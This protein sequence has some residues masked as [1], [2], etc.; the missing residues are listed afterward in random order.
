MVKFF[1]NLSKRDRN[2]LAVCSFF[3]VI[4]VI[5]QFLFLPALAK[6][7][8]LNRVLKINK[9]NLDKMVLL[10]R[11]HRAFNKGSK[12][13]K[14]LLLKRGKRFSLFSFIDRVAESCKLKKN[15]A[16]MKPSFKS[17]DNTDIR[18]AFVKLRLESISLNECVDFLNKIEDRKNMVRINS[19]SISTAGKDKKMIDIVIETETSVLKN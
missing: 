9:S 11:Q 17:L 13:K 19:F 7:K 15:V 5:I 6:R 2:A 8:N 4:F 16:Y 3:L 14:A 18:K 10:N 12:N 1:Q